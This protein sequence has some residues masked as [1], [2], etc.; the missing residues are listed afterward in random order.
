MACGCVR[1]A[2]KREG[3]PQVAREQREEVVHSPDCRVCV[4]EEARHSMS[5]TTILASLNCV[6]GCCRR[7]MKGG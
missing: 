7:R 2:Q 3:S 5:L 6:E 4:E 1:N